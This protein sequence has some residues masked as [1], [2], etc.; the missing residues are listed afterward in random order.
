MPSTGDQSVFGAASPPYTASNPGTIVAQSNR[1]A[2]NWRA[3]WP[4]VTQRAH[5]RPGDMGAD[6]PGP[7]TRGGEKG[8][9]QQNDGNGR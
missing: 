9:A 6:S 7:A 3:A 5:L 8:K 1:A 2:T 4:S